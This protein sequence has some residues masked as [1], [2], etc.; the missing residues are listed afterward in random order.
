MSLHIHILAVGKLKEAFWQQA[1][2]EYSKRLSRYVSLQIVELPDSSR[3]AAGSV[4]AI[5]EREQSAIL[6]ALAR[7]PQECFV[8]ALDIA[9]KPH[10]SPQIA[11]L[12]DQ[13]AGQGHSQ[14]AFLIGGSHGLAAG[15]LGRANLKLSLG[16]ITLPHNLARVVLLEQLYRACC[17]NHQSPYH[18]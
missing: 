1:C 8:V 11:S 16:Q 14:L 7:L 13:A 17:I 4:A 6:A 2:A 5:L 18:K 3:Q 15:V 12:L 10:S 9:G